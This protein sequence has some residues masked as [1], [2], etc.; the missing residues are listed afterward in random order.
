MCLGGVWFQEVLSRCLNISQGN[1][2]MIR[3]STGQLLQIGN[4]NGFWRHCRDS[5]MIIF[6][7]SSTVGSKYESS[8]PS[9]HL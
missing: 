2:H 7:A 8:S 5:A 9:L 3:T 6:L 4:G 1:T